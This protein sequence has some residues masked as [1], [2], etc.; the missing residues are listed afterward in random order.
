LNFDF[1]ITSAHVPPFCL[2]FVSDRTRLPNNRLCPMMPDFHDDVAPLSALRLPGSR[3]ALPLFS[4]ATPPLIPQPLR[5][6][7][8]FFTPGHYFRHFIALTPLK[9]D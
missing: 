6:Q 8:S 5:R 3:R 1:D 4:H 9:Y 2:F 7:F